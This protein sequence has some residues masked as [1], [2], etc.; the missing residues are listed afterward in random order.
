M[1]LLSGELGTDGSQICWQN[2]L[3]ENL[4]QQRKPSAASNLRLDTDRSKSASVLP[5]EPTS[6]ATFENHQLKRGGESAQ[7]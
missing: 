5:F 4:H 1:H 7:S 2:F 6:V 3:P